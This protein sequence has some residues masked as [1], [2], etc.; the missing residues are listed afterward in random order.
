M[1]F[2]AAGYSKQWL[3][4][5]FTFCTASAGPGSANL[6]T[7]ISLAQQSSPLLMLCGDTFLNLPDPVLQQMENF[8]DPTCGVNDAFKRFAVIGIE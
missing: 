3:R 4:Q 6:L 5:R 1:G 8:N 7:A 2:A